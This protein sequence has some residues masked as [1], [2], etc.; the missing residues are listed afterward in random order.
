MKEHIQLSNYGLLERCY[1]LRVI[2]P[3]V[4]KRLPR[5]ALPTVGKVVWGFR[6]QRGVFIL[7][8]DDVDESV[9]GRCDVIAPVRDRLAIS[10]PLSMHR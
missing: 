9:G 1:N 8:R 6:R 2:R 10:L 7:D 3:Y 5:E 4:E